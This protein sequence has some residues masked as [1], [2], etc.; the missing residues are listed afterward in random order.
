MTVACRLPDGASIFTTELVAI[1]LALDIANGNRQRSFLVCSDS[2]SSLQAVHSRKLEHPLVVDIFSKLK[3]LNNKHKEVLFCWVPSHVGMAGNE[4][5][6][7]AAT[8]TYQLD[9]LSMPLPYLGFKPKIAKI[10]HER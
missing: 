9:P 8:E 2:L 6:D 3:K 5:A 7:M 4:R 1:C 10:L